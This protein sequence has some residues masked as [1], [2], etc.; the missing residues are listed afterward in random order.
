MMERRSAGETYGADVTPRND[1]GPTYKGGTDIGDDG[2]IK[3]GH[4]HHIKLAWPR[5]ELH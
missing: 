1:A 4:D 5:D 2:A 3:I